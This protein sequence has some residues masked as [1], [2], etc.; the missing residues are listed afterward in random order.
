VN[1]VQWIYFK[2]HSALLPDFPTSGLPVPLRLPDN[3][4]KINIFAPMRWLA[5]IPLILVTSSLYGQKPDSL[6]ISKDPLDSVNA[7]IQKITAFKLPTDSLSLPE[8]PLDSIERS[9]YTK[10]DSLKSSYRSRIA[11]LDSAMR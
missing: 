8:N 3:H 9:F 5:I 10:A 2:H 11:S 6:A 7:R 1:F 4:F